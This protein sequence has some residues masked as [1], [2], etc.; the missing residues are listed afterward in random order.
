[1]RHTMLLIFALVSWITGAEIIQVDT[2]IKY[3]RL[4]GTQEH[5]PTPVASLRCNMLADSLCTVYFCGSTDSV[6]THLNGETLRVK[7]LFH[8]GGLTVLPDSTWYE[9]AW[10][11]PGDSLIIAGTTT[12][13][14]N[15]TFMFLYY[16]PTDTTHPDTAL[17]GTTLNSPYGG[18]VHYN[19]VL[20]LFLPYNHTGTLTGNPEYHAINTSNHATSRILIRNSIITGKEMFDVTG[21]VRRS[22]IAGL[23]ITK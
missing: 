11:T 1:M 2:I 9:T 12:I 15:I 16:H 21:K 4:D 3:N 10:A 19:L 8:D 22:N 13:Y 14:Y 20:R 5:V 23:V 6:P 18:M 17:F 7:H